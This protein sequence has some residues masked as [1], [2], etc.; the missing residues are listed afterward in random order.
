[1]NSNYYAVIMAGGVGS[2]FWPLSTRKNPK[3]FQD[4]LGTG[5]TL[6]QQTVQRMEP[7]VPVENV[8]I[9]TNAYYLD[10]VHEQLPQIPFKNLLLEPEMRN[11]APCILYSAL[12]IHQTNPDGVMIVAPSDHWI[13]DEDAFSQELKKCF[14]FCTTND[15]L[16]TMGIEPSHPNTGFGY[17]ES[18]KTDHEFKQ[19]KSFKEKPTYDLACKFLE[20]GGFLWNSGIFIWSVR[21]ILKAYKEHLPDMYSLFHEGSD[22]YNTP[23]EASFVTSNYPLA[24]N[25]SID[26]GIME[27]TRDTFVLPVHFGWN[28]LGTWGSLYNQSKKD[29]LNNV[30]I[31]NEAVVEDAEGN[32]IRASKNK[33]IVVKGL[34]DFIVVENEDV[35]LICPKNQEQE[36][37]QLTEKV[38]KKFGDDYV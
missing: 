14:Q 4:L 7:L 15:V 9:A 19:V 16:L 35:L 3:Q 24:E 5:Q 6:I 11:T 17:I 25:V 34:K 20:K 26:Y 33:K 30:F 18:T 36:I 29:D 38:K 12:K 8:L 31:N 13:E 10:L 22:S 32:I 37:K 1:M 2:R 28:D 21:S 27:K 23:K